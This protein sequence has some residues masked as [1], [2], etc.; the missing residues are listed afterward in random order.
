MVRE[1]P[2]PWPRRTGAGGE[3]VTHSE[4]SGA[5]SNHN[6]TS[7]DL[8]LLDWLIWIGQVTVY[9]DIRSFRDKSYLKVM[10]CNHEAISIQCT[11]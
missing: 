6:F 1:V 11:P 8:D 2:S 7:N 10:G 3:A 4:A 9:R 5:R